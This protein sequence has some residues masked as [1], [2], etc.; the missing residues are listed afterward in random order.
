M[1]KTPVAV[2]GISDVVIAVAA[3]E[4]EERGTAMK[5]N[6]HQEQGADCV[7]LRKLSEFSR[8]ELREE[9]LKALDR[10]FYTR[11]SPLLMEFLGTFLEYHADG[12]IGDSKAP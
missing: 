1:R 10:T 7:A 6:D 3:V 2:I 9:F 8:A 4:P 12:S 11:T 5:R